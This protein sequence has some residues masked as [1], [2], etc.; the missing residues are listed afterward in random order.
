MIILIFLL[1]GLNLDF[2]WVA[3]FTPL[4]LFLMFQLAAFVRFLRLHQFLSTVEVEILPTFTD[5]RVISQDY[6]KI[7][8]ALDHYHRNNYQQ[9]A[10]FDKSL[11][12]LTTL[13]THQMKVPLSA[14]DLMVQT[15]RLTASDVEN[16][17]L[18][19]DNYLNILLSYLR[20]QHTATDF[21]FETFDMADII[22]VIIKKYANQFI[23][24]DLSVTVTGS[25][26]VTSDKKW[27]TVAIE[28]LINNAVKY[29][30]KGSVAIVL[31]QGI[32]ISDTGIGILPEDIPR[33]F[34]HGFTGFNGRKMQKSTGLGLYLTKDILKQLNFD[35]KI[36]SQIDQ[37]T[38]V[39]ITPH[40][41]K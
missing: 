34:D 7:I 1:Q 33:I 8:V 15:N 40:D 22:H 41:I 36:T 19:L 29:T 17:V 12:D 38:E 37:G 6:Q 31:D 23:L 5:T 10:S 39:T 18:E 14:L 16:Q 4:L 13:W 28:Q 9:L 35:I 20:L 24:K 2:F 32:L 11:L 30:K 26:Q 25:Y 27:L 21:R 3:L